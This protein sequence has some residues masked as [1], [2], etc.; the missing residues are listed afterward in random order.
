MNE[1]RVVAV[2]PARGGSKGVPGKNLCLVGGVPLVGRAVA[3][4]RDSELIDEVY[5]STDAA[6]IAEAAVSAG[7]TVIVRPDGIAADTSSSEAALLHALD[8]L[9]GDPGILV[10]IQATSPFIDPADLDAAIALVR[11]GA[12]DVVFSAKP[13]HAFL[14][15]DDEQDGAVGVNHD[16]SYRLRRQESEPQFQETGAFYVMRVDGFRQAR[17]RFFGLIGIAVVPELTAI[18][19]DT[20]DD[21]EIACAI[22][23]L[24]DG[25]PDIPIPA[26]AHTQEESWSP[27]A[28]TS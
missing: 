28:R 9:E 1:Q 15:R 16:S 23:P 14:W 26:F 5:V 18:E 22:A 24:I 6:T 13:S 3:S 11:D 21:L 17:F 8:S 25:L 7:A 4:A 10:F 20:L 19:I 12:Y 2:I 27:S